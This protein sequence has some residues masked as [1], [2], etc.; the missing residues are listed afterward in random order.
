MEQ[1]TYFSVREVTEM[2]RNNRVLILTALDD[3]LA[4]L[5]KGSWIGGIANRPEAQYNEDGELQE[6]RVYEL[7]K[8]VRSVHINSYQSFN[9]ELIEKDAFTNGF[10]IICIPAFSSIHLSYSIYSATTPTLRETM[11]GWLAGCECETQAMRESVV[12]DGASGDFYPER[13]VVMHC[14]LPDDCKAWY[15][16]INPY[17]PNLQ[18]PHFK[19]H[20]ASFIV[21]DCSVLSTDEESEVI[22]EGH[23]DNTVDTRVSFKQYATSHNIDLDAETTLITKLHGEYI[24]SSVL[25]SAIGRNLILSNPVIPGLAYY[26]GQRSQQEEGLFS[27]N[28]QS[29]IFSVDCLG[30]STISPN[31]LPAYGGV[32][33]FTYNRVVI[34]LHVTRS[35]STLFPSDM[36]QSS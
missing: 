21:S 29:V 33:R 10:S 23:P 19:F 31:S 8:W 2:I 13:A 20:N 11:V 14:A 28:A 22:Q 9:F 5:P 35:L 34:R 36:P 27:A 26:I 15:D 12:V 18:K 30:S 17:T 16:I 3:V 25:V 4:Q 6:I 32:A 24:T 1:R 7:T